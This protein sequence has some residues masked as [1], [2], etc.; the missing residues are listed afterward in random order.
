MQALNLHN[1]IKNCILV[2]S[3]PLESIITS[4]C[5]WLRS[6][7]NFDFIPLHRKYF[8]AI[9]ISLC[10]SLTPKSPQP[11]RSHCQSFAL[12]SIT[13]N[14]FHEKVALCHN[15]HNSVTNIRPPK[16][17]KVFRLFFTLFFF[18]LRLI[19]YMLHTQTIMSI[20]NGI[21][22]IKESTFL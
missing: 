18:S 14:E 20:C 9:K 22:K 4:Y 16:L 21:K 12:C 17:S 7:V 6:L 11:K 15:Y 8:F 10:H 3:I 2:L 19:L 5:P 13:I 1:A